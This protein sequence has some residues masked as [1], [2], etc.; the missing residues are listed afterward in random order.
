LAQLKQLIQGMLVLY[1]L[2]TCF[3][4]YNCPRI[5]QNLNK[6]ITGIQKLGLEGIP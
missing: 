6:D 5:N 4:A 3:Q 2:K 1:K